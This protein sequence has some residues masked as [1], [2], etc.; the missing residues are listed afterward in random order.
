MKINKKF[1]YGLRAMVELAIYYKAGPLSARAI[2]RVES[3]PLQ[4]LEQIFNL[5]K[6]AGLVKTVRGSRGGYLLSREPSKIRV[7]H[8]MNVLDAGPYLADCLASKRKGGCNRIDICTVTKF[9]QRL[10]KSIRTVVESTTLKDLAAKRP[11]GAGIEHNYMFQ[12]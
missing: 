6:K 9:W 10:S 3:I 5:L 7:S 4:Y 1:R 12:I 11:K 8:L 2:S